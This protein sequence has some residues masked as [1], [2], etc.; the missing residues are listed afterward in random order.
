MVQIR[1][2]TFWV[3]GLGRS[4]SG[5]DLTTNGTC[6][7][8]DIKYGKIMQSFQREANVMTKF[9]WLETSEENQEN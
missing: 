3:E 1:F 7:W 5:E 4:S 8:I 6:T 2:G 9:G